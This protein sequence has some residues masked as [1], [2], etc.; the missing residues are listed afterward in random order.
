MFWVEFYLKWFIIRQMKS[1]WKPSE[2]WERQMLTIY[3]AIRTSIQGSSDGVDSDIWA[4]IHHPNGQRQYLSFFPPS[5]WPLVPGCVCLC[6]HGVTLRV[7]CDLWV[8]IP[9][10]QKM[11]PF[12]WA[13]RSL[14]A[15]FG[16]ISSHQHA[17][18]QGRGRERRRASFTSYRI[19]LYGS[20][21]FP[22]YN[23]K[24]TDG[25]DAIFKVSDYETNLH[26]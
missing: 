14:T 23:T 2:L 20:S 13:S 17:R 19:N 6:V 11:L 16:L 5:S 7:G 24:T 9:I 25:K 26:I 8:P 1:A 22:W 12:R 4:D 15:R 3:R 21:D 18:T 10:H